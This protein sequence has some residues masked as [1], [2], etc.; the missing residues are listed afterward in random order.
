MCVAKTKWGLVK[1]VQLATAGT[2]RGLCFITFSD[3]HLPLPAFEAEGGEPSSPMESVE[4]V[5]YPGLWVSVFDCSCVQLSKIDTETQTTVLL[6]HHDHRRGPRTVGGVDDVA[7]QH[8][9][10]LRHLLP[11]NSRVLSSIGLA[12]RRPMGLNRVLQQRTTP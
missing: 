9:L 10:D 1:L 4:E 6:P 8:L 2:K 12:E 11:L 7:G 5:V 3:E